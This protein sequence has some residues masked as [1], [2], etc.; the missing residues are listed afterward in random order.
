[1]DDDTGKSIQRKCLR[2]AVIATLPRHSYICGPYS[3]KWCGEDI[4]LSFI[5]VVV[6]Q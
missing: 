5:F 6:Q 4:T 3:K 2:L 1:M